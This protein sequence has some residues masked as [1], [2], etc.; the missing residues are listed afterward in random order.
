[1]NTEQ[2]DYVNAHGTSTPLGDK[3]EVAAVLSIFGNHARKSARAA[4]C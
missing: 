2:I 4:S 3:A 1:M